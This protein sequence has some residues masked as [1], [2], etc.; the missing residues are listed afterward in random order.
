MLHLLTMVVRIDRDVDSKATG[1]DPVI[2]RVLSIV[3]YPSRS[4]P[5]SSKYHIHGLFPALAR[6]QK[7]VMVLSECLG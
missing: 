5:T 2:A 6:Q 3:F 1:F 4:I 7:L